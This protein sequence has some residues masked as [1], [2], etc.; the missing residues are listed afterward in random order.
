LLPLGCALLV[1]VR[2]KNLAIALLFQCLS[3]EKWSS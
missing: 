1:W 3:T 2:L